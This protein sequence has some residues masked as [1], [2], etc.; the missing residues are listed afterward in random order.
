MLFDVG[1][2]LADN[3]NVSIKSAKQ[4]RLSGE[5][6]QK[7]FEDMIA[8]LKFHDEVVSSRDVA[9]GLPT[10]NRQNKPIVMTNGF[11]RD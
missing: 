4:A 7:G 9:T 5:D 8:G 10:G 3:I 6:L 11:R 1:F 2:M